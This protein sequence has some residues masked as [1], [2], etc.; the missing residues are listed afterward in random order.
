[1]HGQSKRQDKIV[2]KDSAEVFWLKKISPICKRIPKQ[3]SKI[4]AEQ[5]CLDGK[6]WERL[7]SISRMHKKGMQLITFDQDPAIL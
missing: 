6:P 4:Q 2:G 3:P 5:N 1:M 7:N